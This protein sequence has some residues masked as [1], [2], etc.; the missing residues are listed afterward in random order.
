MVSRSSGYLLCA[1]I[2]ALG[3]S[4]TATQATG[5]PSGSGPG[6]A[7]GAGGSG[8][9]STSGGDGGIGGNVTT[10]ETGVGPISVDSGE[11]STQCIYIRL[12]N[13]DPVFVRR[14]KATLSDASHHMIVYR[15]NKTDEQLTPQPCQSFSGL[16]SGEHAIFI[17]QQKEATLLF[18]TDG[19]VPVG[20]KI[21]AN[22]MVRIEMHYVNA[23]AAPVDAIGKAY[24]DTVPLDT[25]VIESDLAFWGTDQIDI[26]PNSTGDTG[27]QFQ[28]GLSATKTFAVTTH[29][30]HLGTRMRVWQT[31]SPDSL[32]ETP[33]ADS[34][35]WSD[36]P[37]V[38]LDP[39]LEFPAGQ[40]SMSPSGFAYRCEWKNTTSK[41]VGFG[42][43][44]EDE[45]CFLWH[46]YFP[47][48]GFQ[49]CFDGFCK[50]SP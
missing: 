9:G 34:T 16:L 43:K 36:P 8:A 10:F 35:S 1:G 49:I 12:T 29:Q 37:L 21:E 42:E 50:N 17:A 15:S 32:P 40:S 5:S 48:Q 23:S 30:H 11:Q 7:T 6:G 24:L 25:N 4:S 46:Y 22:Q 38:K 3:C 33:V 19:D 18:P 41:T 14:F 47:S 27:V 20:L 39:P 45:M 28:L 26:P 44:V 2:L 31:E 13:P